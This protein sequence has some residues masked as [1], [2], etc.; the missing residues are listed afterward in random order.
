M[1]KSGKTTDKESS[2]THSSAPLP[3]V[4]KQEANR[5]LFEMTIPT[6]ATMKKLSND[7]KINTKLLKWRVLINVTGQPMVKD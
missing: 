3:L 1:R 7:S 2:R 6:K 4:C 5:E